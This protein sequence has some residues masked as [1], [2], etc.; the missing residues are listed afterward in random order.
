M[1]VRAMCRVLCG[2][3]HQVE[4]AT[5]P[6]G[7]D[8]ALPGLRI[9]RSLA[10]PGIREV[11]IGFS[12]QKLAL[13]A[14]L[15]LLVARLLLT[16]RYDAVHAVEEGAYL[17]LPF[18]LLGC[19]LIC[20]LDSLISDQLRYAGVIRSARLLR[21]VR[22]LEALAL[23][24]SSAAI[25]VCRSL[26]DAALAL[27]PSAR[28][29]QIEDTPLEESMREPDPQRVEALRD[30]LGLRGRPLALY[31]GNLEAYQGVD[32]LLAA[33]ER[34]ARLRPNAA[35]V[36]VGGDAPS[37]A[38][39]R[40]RIRARGLAQHVLA[41]GPR[42]AQEMPEWMALG[43]LLVSPRCEGENTPLK[44]YT[45]MYAGRPIVATALPTHT[46]VLDASCALLCEPNADALASALERGLAEP[47]ALASLASA[48]RARVE[49]D[50]S[51]AAFARKLLAVYAFVLGAPEAAP[52]LTARSA[53]M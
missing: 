28:V 1:N 30:E 31:T 4:L 20:D 19:R 17:A 15:A 5:Y 11:R 23:R 8:I 7:E 53:S 22:V 51:P 43:D 21:A 25:T 13:D 36:L 40:E 39:C 46:Q 42:P 2:A 50:F 26:T 12:L 37:L 3:G 14:G 6:I 16:R 35:C 32:L 45:Y 27:C 29:F 52:R 9:R 18:T 44:I 34:V 24:R 33:M 41:V 48:A 49:R 10:L 47:R 38:A